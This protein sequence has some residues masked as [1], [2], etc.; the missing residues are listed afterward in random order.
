MLEIRDLS[1]RYGRKN[2]PA[3]QSV[4]LTLPDGAIGILLGPNGSGKTTLF[5]AVTGSQKPLSGSVL[6]NGCDLLSMN[7]RKRSL[8]V[9]YV[10]QHIHFGSLSVYDS[11]LLGRI[12]R[13]R[14]TAGRRDRE[15]TEE[16]LCELNLTHLRDRDA[17][18][19]SGGEKQLVAIARALAQEP[20]LLVFDEPTGNLDIANELLVI[21]ETK[22]IAKKR[23]LAVF[24]SLHD[25]N[26]ALAFGD[27]FYFLKNGNLIS[28]G[29]SEIITPELLKEIYGVSM[30]IAS[31]D[32][33]PVV[34]GGKE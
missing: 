6:L 2:P 18:T 13:F 1:F 19:L 25:L 16:V 17:E 22:R 24:A 4:S 34:I 9:S 10:P 21:E 20:A 11:V 12:S 26:E 33:T 7:E 5:R 8:Y 28:S 31:V 29:T 14:F 3:L 15:V 23:N 27:R 32:G 30:K